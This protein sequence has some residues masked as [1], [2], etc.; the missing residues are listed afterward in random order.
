MRRGRSKTIIELVPGHDALAL[1][2][3]RPIQLQA[4]ARAIRVVV[5]GVDPV[6]DELAFRY[7][8]ANLHV[9]AGEQMQLGGR[10]L[11][12]LHIHKAPLSPLDHAGGGHHA[13]VNGPHHLGD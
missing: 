8:H 3:H 2:E 6:H 1:E 13:I 4:Q 7:R 5:L 12:L 9:L 11:I 10:I